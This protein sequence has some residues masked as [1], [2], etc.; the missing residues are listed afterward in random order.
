VSRVSEPKNRSRTMAPADETGL[1]AEV[2][3]F[4][5]DALARE[6]DTALAERVIAELA[7]VGL[8]ERR[9]VIEWRHHLLPH[10]Y[11]VYGLGWERQAAIVVAALEQVR[12][13]DLVGRGGLFFYSHLHDQMRMGKN[14]LRTLATEQYAA[15]LRGGAGDGD[16]ADRH[17]AGTG[18]V[19]EGPD[20]D[21][22]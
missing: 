13:L 4:P 11:P 3:C 12:N 22:A 17:G 1:V 20:A 16:C 19:V 10:A 18:E 7:G 21:L 5:D 14:Y 15:A 8:L 2:P 9:E 6:P